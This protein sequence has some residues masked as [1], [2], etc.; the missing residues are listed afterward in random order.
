MKAGTHRM[1]KVEIVIETVKL[2]AVLSI[3]D[4]AGAGGYTIF[5]SVTGRGHRGRRAGIALTNVFHNSL[6]FTL[7]DE[8]T[9][10]N[11]GREVKPLI[12]D[13]AGVIVIT[14]AE[15]IWPNYEQDQTGPQNL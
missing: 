5:P 6:V 11:I 4:R 10:A 15:V 12:Q 8:T 1:K 9:A 3:I 14:D 7:V 13:Y 2:P